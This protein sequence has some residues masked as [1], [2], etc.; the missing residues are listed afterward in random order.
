MTPLNGTAVKTMASFMARAQKHAFIQC[1]AFGGEV[2]AVP[3]S[4]NAFPWR[5]APFECQVYSNSGNAHQDRSWIDG[6][7][8]AMHPLIGSAEYVNYFHCSTNP[9]KAYFGPHATRLQQIKQA[10]DPTG[11]IGGLYCQQDV[12]ID[13]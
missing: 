6:L 11:Q 1:R 9:W 4:F 5:A 8:A 3:V 12:I 10:Y 13:E 2:N 7:L